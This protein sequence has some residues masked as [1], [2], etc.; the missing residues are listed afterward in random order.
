MNFPSDLSLFLGEFLCSIFIPG[1][2][3]GAGHFH[4]PRPSNNLQQELA[5]WCAVSLSLFVRLFSSRRLL[6][7]LS[8]RSMSLYTSLKIVYKIRKLIVIS[9]MPRAFAMLSKPPA[10][11][12][13]RKELAQNSE[14]I[15]ADLV[16]IYLAPRRYLWTQNGNVGSHFEQLGV[17]PAHAKPVQRVFDVLTSPLFFHGTWDEVSSLL[18]PLMNLIFYSFSLLFLLFF[19]SLSFLFVFSFFSLSYAL[20]YALFP[21][22]FQNFINLADTYY[23]NFF[24]EPLQ[25]GNIHA[26]QRAAFFSPQGTMYEPSPSFL[27][28]PWPP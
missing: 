23:M 4:S 8:P 14:R 15:R 6:L 28:P 10:S 17:S 27:L 26:I 16:D 9:R 25:K 11:D 12:T 18:S 22:L 7:H 24:G 13:E 19:F 3:R 1:C 20:S 5:R 21:F 2:S